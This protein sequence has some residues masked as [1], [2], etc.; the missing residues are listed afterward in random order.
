MGD[1]ALLMS[2]VRPRP[3]LAPYVD[4]LF[5][6]TSRAPGP[7][8]RRELPV[9]RAVLVVNL[10]P[11]LWIRQGGRWQAFPDGLLAGMDDLSVFTGTRTGLQEGVQALLTPLG[12]QRLA[13]VAMH[14]LAHRSFPLEDVLGAPWREIVER[15]H[16]TTSWRTRLVLLED[17]LAARV[18]EARAAPPDVVWAWERLERAHGTVP[19]AALA[20]ELRC[21]ERHLQARFRDHVGISPKRA[22]RVL[23]FGR[24]VELL[25]AGVPQARAAAEAG[26]AD[27]AHLSREVRR[28]TGLPPGALLAERRSGSYKIGP[29]PLA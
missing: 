25:E 11:P 29:L 2:S 26:F 20:A 18:L 15:M 17:A 12:C 9:P 1:A 27:Q 16:G 19:V 14:E 23:R 3:A 28:V 8:E 10:G 6:Y 24:A 22:A 7:E 13:G 4:A 5:A 21:S